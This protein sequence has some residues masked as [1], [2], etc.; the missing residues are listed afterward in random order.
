MRLY[1]QCNR[2]LP[3]GAGRLIAVGGA[4]HVSTITAMEL[5]YAFGRLDPSDPRTARNLAY[6]RD[7][8]ER[9]PRHRVIEATPADHAFAGVIAGTLARSQ[10]LSGEGRKRLLLDSLIFASARRRGLTVLTANTDDFDLL[11]QLAP[12]GKVAFY[13][14]GP[15][16]TEAM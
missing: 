14:T 3:L 1:R 9:V 10:G 8:L 13:R 7:V 4:A 15:R 2:R 12:D 5:T 6:L 11:Q 16:I